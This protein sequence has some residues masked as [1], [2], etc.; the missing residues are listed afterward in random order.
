MRRCGGDEDAFVRVDSC[1][2][3]GGRLAD[4]HQVTTSRFGGKIP[5]A[6]YTVG[7]VLGSRGEMEIGAV[8]GAPGESKDVAWFSHA[9]DTAQA[10]RGGDLVFVT[11]C[12]GLQG[13]KSEIV[14]GLRGDRR[15]Q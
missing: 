10:T 9:P 3:D 11:A 4:W 14:E 5:F 15:G 7:T 6:H 1:I 2:R 13:R 8:A 12:S